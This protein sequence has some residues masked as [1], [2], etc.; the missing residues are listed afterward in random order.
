MLR[1]RNY[2]DGLINCPWRAKCNPARR[3]NKEGS[4]SPIGFWTVTFYWR[5]MCLAMFLSCV[6][7]PPTVRTQTQWS[8]E[9]VFLL[10]FCQ[11]FR[12]KY[13]LIR[14]AL[15]VFL[16]KEAVSAER[17]SFCSYSLFLQPDCFKMRYYTAM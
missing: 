5:A 9:R 11:N 17:T 15:S 3:N 13:F 16:Q 1:Y 12:Q 14:N 10:P 6:S 4:D 7:A 2:R 8:N